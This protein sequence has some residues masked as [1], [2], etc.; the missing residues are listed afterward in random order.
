M[1]NLIYMCSDIL[2]FQNMFEYIESRYFAR[3]LIRDFKEL[4]ARDADI[5]ECYQKQMYR[6]VQLQI[7]FVSVCSSVLAVLTHSVCLL[8]GGAWTS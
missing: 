6:Y 7:E 2:F 4:Q 3:F 1:N 8:Q 5:L